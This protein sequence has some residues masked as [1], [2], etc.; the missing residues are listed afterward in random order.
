[1]PPFGPTTGVAPHGLASR[2][3]TFPYTHPTIQK[4]AVIGAGA[5]GTA[6]AITAARAGREVSLWARE[7]EVV[8]QIRN[9]RENKVF[10]PNQTLPEG[11]RAE[12]RIGDALRDADAALLVVPS[13]FLRA[14]CRAMAPMIGRGM[15]VVICAKGVE[16]DSGC[17]CPRSSKRRC[18][19]TRWRSCRA[20]LRA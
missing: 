8:E 2:Q 11:I 17:C 4:I 12:Q 6:L 20:H 1:M 7:A 10:L 15:P 18:R 13:Q 19:D 9:H 5:W 16:R 3:R 14:T